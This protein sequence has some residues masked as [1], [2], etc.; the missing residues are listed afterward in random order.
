MVLLVRRAH[1]DSAAQTM[2][3]VFTVK[4][5]KLALEMGRE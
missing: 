1:A 3:L 2:D 5:L 4:P